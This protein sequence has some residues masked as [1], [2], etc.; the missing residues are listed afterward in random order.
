[1]EALIPPCAAIECALLGLS[2]KQNDLIL[3]PISAKDAA[4][5]APANPV[6]ITMISNFCLFAGLTNGK[7]DL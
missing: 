5:D 2:W 3:Y 4:A 7:L 6:P 1:M